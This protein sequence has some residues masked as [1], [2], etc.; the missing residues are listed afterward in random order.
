MTALDAALGYAVLGWPVFPCRPRDKRPATEHGFLDATC[1]PDQISA[2]WE[3]TTP[4]ANVGIATGPA[5][6]AVVDVD[7]GGHESLDQLEHQHGLLP[8][9]RVC[10]TPRGGFHLYYRVPADRTSP[11]SSTGRLGPGIDIR[12][13][14]G[15]VIAPPSIGKN[16]MPYLWPDPTVPLAAAPGWLLD[17]CERA[18][19]SPAPVPR[20][21]SYPQRGPGRR[22]RYVYAVLEREAREVAAT[23]PGSR[24]ERLYQAAYTLSRFVARGDLPHGLLE[25]VLIAAGTDAGLPK[26][27]AQSTITSALKNR[28]V[29]A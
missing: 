24:N 27:E 15:Y 7:P 20:G 5:G 16:G 9:T 6:L 17:L 28:G 12:S 11:P 19:P 29:T 3:T 4:D 22:G 23:P 18:D 1:D 26:R 14:G 10:W 2:W 21:T 25:R 8:D 13:A